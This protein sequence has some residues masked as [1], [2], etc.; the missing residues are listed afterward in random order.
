MIPPVV[1]VSVSP[2]LRKGGWCQTFTG[3]K[4]WP[5]DPRPEDIDIIDI[6]HALANVCRFGGHSR[7]FYS[8]AQHSVL[9]SQHCPAEFAMHG[10]MHDA[11]EAYIGDMV[12]P[13]K[14][15]DEMIAYRQAEH[16]IN[17]AIATRFDMWKW[18][19]NTPRS[20]KRTDDATLA[21]EAK[22][23]MGDT[24]EWYLPEPPLPIE[25]VAVGPFEA[26]RMF[27]RRFEELGGKL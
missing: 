20:V 16:A 27:L 21:T 18:C 7:V 1:S 19:H 6:A 5:L 23:F 3:R 13:L 8:V 9:V 15:Q 14:T 2:D 4:F 17:G 26:K 11:A 24:N 10:L 22:W 25:I 12:R